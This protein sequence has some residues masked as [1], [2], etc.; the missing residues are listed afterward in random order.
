MSGFELGFLMLAGL[1]RVGALPSANAL[2][3]FSASPCSF[4]RYSSAL[5]CAQSSMS[6]FKVRVPHARWA[7][8]D[9]R[10]ALRKHI[11]LLLCQPV[12]LLQVQLRV[13]L[14]PGQSRRSII[15]TLSFLAL[16]RRVEYQ[17]I[18]VQACCTLAHCYEYFGQSHLGAGSTAYQDLS[19]ARVMGSNLQKVHLLPRPL[20]KTWDNRPPC[21]ALPHLTTFPSSMHAPG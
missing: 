20:L 18:R 4:S 10:L 11:G 1:L 5:P 12:Q 13:A 2:D 16:I 14:R 15:Q 6:G 19:A 8:Q 17:S 7:A 21:F 9:G 3:S